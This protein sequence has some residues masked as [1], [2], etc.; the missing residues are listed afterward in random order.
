[1]KLRPP[2]VGMLSLPVLSLPGAGM[3]SGNG[4]DVRGTLLTATRFSC[5]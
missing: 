5:G 1:M 3:L 2:G 4:A